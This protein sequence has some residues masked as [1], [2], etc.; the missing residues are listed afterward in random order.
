[1]TTPEDKTEDGFETQ[2]GI[3]HLGHFLLF[4]L[5]KPTLL[6]SATPDFPSRVVSLSSMGHRYGKVRPHDY[7][8]T[9][10]GSYDPGAAYG[11]AKTANIWFA[12]ELERRYGSRNLHAT[13]LHP[14]GI[15]T[16]LQKHWDPQLKETLG[17]K[18]EVIAYMMNAAQ[19]AATSIYAGLSEE[20]KFKGGKYLSKCVEQ[21]PA[22][23]TEA[24]GVQVPLGDD[25][26][27]SWAF[28]EA[29]EKQLWKDSL[30]MMGLD[31]DQ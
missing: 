13:S 27:A 29:S 2:L 14:G 7:N 1:M 30:G 22:A 20:W 12:N 21:G 25:G 17:A 11:Q 28:D 5:L 31:D 15:W 19:G 6:A 16:G 4:H 8:F 24:E 9:E 3:N 26:Y 23:G 10:P 18:E